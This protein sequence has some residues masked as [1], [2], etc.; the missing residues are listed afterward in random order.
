ML[1]SKLYQHSDQESLSLLAM[2]V[3]HG[4]SWR[5][6]AQNSRKGH[7][8]L[9][10]SGSYDDAPSATIIMH[11]LP[12][13]VLSDGYDKA[14]QANTMVPTS[15]YTHKSTGFLPEKIEGAGETYCSFYFVLEIFSLW[16]R[17]QER[18]MSFCI[19]PPAAKR[20]VHQAAI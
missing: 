18:E 13:C 3:N 8:P 9:C 10:T 2:V 11:L 4:L 5:T 6:Y 17:L 1:V 20:Q 14:P 19:P 7:R 16:R 15:H 12:L